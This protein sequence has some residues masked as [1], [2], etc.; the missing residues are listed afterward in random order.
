MLHYSDFFLV[1]KGFFSFFLKIIFHFLFIYLFFDISNF[2]GYLLSNPSLL[3]K[4]SFTI[5]P[6]GFFIFLV[7]LFL[8]LHIKLCGLF[9]DE[10]TIIKE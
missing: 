7:F 9:I 4:S 10:S 8:F 6:L 1:G 5:L 3:K 2:E